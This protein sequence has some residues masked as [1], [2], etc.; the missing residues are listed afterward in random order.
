MQLKYAALIELLLE[1]RSLVDSPNTNVT[2]SRFK[3][4]DEVLEY[5]DSCIESLRQ[6]S[7]S[8]LEDLKLLFAPTGSLQEISIDSGWGNKFIED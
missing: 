7:E 8:A 5:L 1:V 3:D 4:V 6:G 2:W